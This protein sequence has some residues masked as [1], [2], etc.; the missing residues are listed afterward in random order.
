V[1]DLLRGQPGVAISNQGGAGKLSSVFMRGT[2]ANHVL[3]LVLV[4]GIKVG[5]ATSGGFAWQDMPLDQIERIEIVRGPRSA[6][7]G[8]EAIGGVIQIF[9]RKGDGGFAPS[10]SFGAGSQG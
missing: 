6:L 10:I 4:D 3:V 1:L 9:T 8:S 2:N 7:Y 5:S